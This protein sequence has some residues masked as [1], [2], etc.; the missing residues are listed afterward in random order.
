MKESSLRLNN[1]VVKYFSKSI[2]HL[3]KHKAL[4]KRFVAYVHYL[5]QSGLLSCI[6]NNLKVFYYTYYYFNYIILQNHVKRQQI[7]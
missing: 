6:E 4:K 5:F 7:Y 1:I 3:A 2:A